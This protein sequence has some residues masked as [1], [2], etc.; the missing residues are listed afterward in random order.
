MSWDTPMH[1]PDPSHPAWIIL[2]G[3]ALLALIGGLPL[4]SR[5]PWWVRDAIMLATVMLM[6]VALMQV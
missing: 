3:C 4:A 2:G 1:L 5:L 6:S